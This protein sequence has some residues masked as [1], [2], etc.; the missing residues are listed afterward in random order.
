MLESNL[1]NDED[2]AERVL[3]ADEFDLVEPVVRK[4][5]FLVDQSQ[6]RVLEGNFV[7]ES[8]RGNVAFRQDVK[9]ISDEQITDNQ[10]N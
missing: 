4:L 7:V 10:R 8:R 9:G 6:I 2:C 3:G 1:F 5:V